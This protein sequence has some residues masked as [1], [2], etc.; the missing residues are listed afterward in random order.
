MS[1]NVNFDFILETKEFMKLIPK[2]N[3]GIQIVQMNK[4]PPDYLDLERIN[5]NQR[6]QLL[7]NECD[8]LFDLE[9]P[10]ATDYGTLISSNLDY[11]EGLI[12][13]KHINWNDLP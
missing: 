7:L 8:Y 11:M 4:I 1:K 6:Y 12:A 2:W 3:A 10:S 13:S 5:G 9:I